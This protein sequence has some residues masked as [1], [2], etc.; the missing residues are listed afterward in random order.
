MVDIVKMSFKC[1]L[2]PIHAG[3]IGITCRPHMG[4]HSSPMSD[5]NHGNTWVY[6]CRHMWACVL[7]SPTLVT[8]LHQS[9]GYVCVMCMCMLEYVHACICLHLLYSHEPCHS[10]DLAQVAYWFQ[11]CASRQRNMVGVLNL[12]IFYLNNIVLPKAAEICEITGSFCS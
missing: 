3:G 11:A 4:P 9:W 1:S 7:F 5:I 12:F 2:V 8:L 10:W 6:V